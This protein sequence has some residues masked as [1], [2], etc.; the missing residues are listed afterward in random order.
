MGYENY[1]LPFFI[2]HH[3]QQNPADYADID[4][5]KTT[6]VSLCK[7]DGMMTLMRLMIHVRNAGPSQISTSTS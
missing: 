7:W 3:Q 5:A 6:L 1:F 2:F 4:A